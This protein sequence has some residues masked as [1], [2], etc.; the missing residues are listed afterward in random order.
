MGAFAGTVIDS[1]ANKVIARIRAIIFFIQTLPDSLTNQG[2]LGMLRLSLDE[3]HHYAK[4]AR[5]S[6]GPVSVSKGGSCVGEIRLDR[7]G[8]NMVLT[9]RVKRGR[10]SIPL[11]TIEVP[12]QNF[13]VMS[14]A[15]EETLATLRKSQGNTPILGDTG[16]V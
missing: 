3:V 16:E 1:L 9:F 2:I 4:Q 13:T 5:R 10:K 8:D 14:E 15:I 12:K 7:R 11:T 6:D